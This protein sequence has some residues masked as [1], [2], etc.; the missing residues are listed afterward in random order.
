MNTS[1][2]NALLVRIQKCTATVEKKLAV[3][4][5]FKQLVCSVAKSCL[6]LCDLTDYS[7]PGSDS[8]HGISYARIL[9]WVA[10]KQP[11]QDIIHIVYNSLI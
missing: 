8:V 2:S 3:Y 4:Y 6:I 7:P 10:I 5:F 1:T 9:E 11:Y